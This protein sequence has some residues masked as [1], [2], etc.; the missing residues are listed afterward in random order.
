MGGSG[1]GLADATAQVLD[2]HVRLA[3]LQLL[4]GQPMG[5]ASDVVLY[6]ALGALG[7]N[8]VYQPSRDEARPALNDLISDLTASCATGPCDAV[9]TR[10]V[11][12]GVCAAVLSSA[13]ATVQ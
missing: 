12:K 13:A 6:E 10:N 9:R 11:V 1:M 8:I 7:A 5:N 2:R 4:A 3:I